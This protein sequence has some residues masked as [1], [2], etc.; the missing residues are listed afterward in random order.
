MRP[1]CIGAAFNILQNPKTVDL[2]LGEH[3]AL[4]FKRDYPRNISVE[5]WTAQREY[6]AVMLT[7]PRRLFVGTR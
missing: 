3:K 4:S 7:S 5:N 6:A 2:T 1:R